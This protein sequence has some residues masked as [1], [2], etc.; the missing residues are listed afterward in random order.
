MGLLPYM[1]VFVKVVELGSFSAAAEKLGS[2]AS[3]VSRQ[4]ASL[5]N[6]LGVKLLERTTR[7]LRL[8]EAGTVAW[9]RCF[10]MMQ[11]AKSV[12]ELAG[13]IS[14]TPQGRVRIS[15]PRAYGKDLISPHVAEF[16]QRYPEIDLQLML[17]DRMVDLISDDV[18]LAIRITDTPPPGL[19]ARPLFPVRHVLCASA[20]YLQ[21]HGIPEHPQD[22]TQ[23]NCIYLGEVP[24]DNQWKFRHITNGEQISVAVH[25]RYAS[26][27]SKARLEGII[28][29]L[30]IGCLPRFSAQQV[31]D[32]RQIIQVLPE[33][34][35]MTSYYGMSWILYHPNRYLPPKC[36]VLIDFLLEKLK[37]QTAHLQSH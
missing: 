23:H 8:T 16:L 36:R 32:N 29:H 30:G 34:D 33:W 11:S 15:A 6:A 28:H 37:H 13:R 10:E 14:D 21:Q 35:Y 5:E 2:T 1:A 3:S 12:F 7:R 17:T 24:G 27:H 19:V 4:I 31:M 18:D 22:L 26:N 9:E 20:E 25:G